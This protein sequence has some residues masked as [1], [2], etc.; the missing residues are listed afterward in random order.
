MQVNPTGVA[1]IALGAVVGA[2]LGSVL[3]GLA[4]ALTV[5][6]LADLAEGVKGPWE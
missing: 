5:V 1:V 6:I 2:L 3:W 4:V